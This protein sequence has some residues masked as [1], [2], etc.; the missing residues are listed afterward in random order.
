MSA[1]HPFLNI[2]QIDLDV[3]YLNLSRFVK[4]QLSSL[5]LTNINIMI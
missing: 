5:L 1:P 4:L 3:L 2:S